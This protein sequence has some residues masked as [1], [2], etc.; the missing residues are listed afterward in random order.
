MYNKPNS[1]F[2]GSESK[3]IIKGNWIRNEQIKHDY[4][5]Y[6]YFIIIIIIIIII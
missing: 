5:C 3:L 2:C 6:Y 4:Y 1:A